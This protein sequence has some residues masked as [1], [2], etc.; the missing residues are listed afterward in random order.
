MGKFVVTN[1]WLA[2]PDRP[3]YVLPQDKAYVCAFNRA[4]AKTASDYW[5]NLDQTPEP[6]LGPISAPVIVL[7]LN[8]S[9]SKSEALPQ[10]DRERAER[11]LASIKNE[12]REHLGVS[13]PDAWWTPRL[14]QLANDVGSGPLL[15]NR[16]C[17][18]EFF[19]YRSR[20]FSH[21]CIR[22]PSQTYTFSLVRSGIER[23]ALFIVTRNVRL[24]LA[25]IPELQDRL[26]NKVFTL[27]NPQSTYFTESNL[28]AGVY[29]QLVDAIV[30]G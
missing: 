8:P 30:N 26:N 16:I 18:I 14:R 28:P 2:L 19:P 25:A 20:R 10:T 24:W 9:Y 5:I 23:G 4:L 29:R 13:R 11:N 27:N 12:D 1:P 15:A 17:S 21:G 3:P 7:Q 22:L 6:R